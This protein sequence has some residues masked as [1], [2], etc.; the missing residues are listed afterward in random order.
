MSQGTD[1]GLAPHQALH[2]S[3]QKRVGSGGGRADWPH[4]F[5]SVPEDCCPV[6]RVST[7]GL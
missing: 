5:E 6:R 2:N 7:R 1:W 3:Q 4:L